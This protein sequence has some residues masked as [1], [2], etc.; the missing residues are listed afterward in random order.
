MQQAI[1]PMWDQLPSMSWRDKV[2]LLT[3]QFLQT[4]QIDCPVTHSFDDYETYTRD[5]LIPADT[6][7]LGRAHRHGHECQLLSGSLIHISPQGKRAIEAPFTM[8]TTPGYHM[9]LYAV[10]DCLGR[11][12]HPNPANVRDTE[13]LENDIFEPAETLRA[14]GEQIHKMLTCQV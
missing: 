10:T 4:P 12:V 6:L 8:F 14:L 3:F 2:A 5:M 13:W 7:F 11:T 9:V 1:I